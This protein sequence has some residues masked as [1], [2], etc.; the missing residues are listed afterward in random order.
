MALQ[1]FSSPSLSYNHAIQ[2]VV[3]V[4]ASLAKKPPTTNNAS[5]EAP[6]DPFEDPSNQK[7]FGGPITPTHSFIFNKF[8][9]VD[10]HMV[11]VTK[12]FESQLDPLTVKDM[13][14][15]WKCIVDL[16]GLGFYNGGR[17]AGASQPHK[18]L[19]FL[20]L[21]LVPGAPYDLPIESILLP[22]DSSAK[23][24]QSGS[25]APSTSQPSPSYTSMGH[26]DITTH[27]SLPFYNLY[28]PIPEA[29]LASPEMPTLLHRTYL[30]MLRMAEPVYEEH[31]VEQPY[32][33][34][35][36][37][38]KRWLLFVPRSKECIDNTTISINSMGFAGTL[39]VKSM[40]HLQVVKDIGPMG[41]LK[42]LTLPTPSVPKL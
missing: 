17:L 13:D 41:V 12:E 14:A 11:I 25:A 18:H 36:L 6:K 32:C 30:Q 23:G 33:F 31:N 3:R 1:I 39:F 42:A 26:L 35:M 9:L 29:L 34:N 37:L 8:N 19:Q 2:F 22:R 27:P 10:D 20:P 38:T 28:A 16:G 7:L 40:E 15:V 4:A 24:S 21:P 5:T